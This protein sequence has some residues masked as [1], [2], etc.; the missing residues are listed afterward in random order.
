MRIILRFYTLILIIVIGWL[1]LMVLNKLWHQ[2]DERYCRIILS[3]SNFSALIYSWVSFFQGCDDYQSS[4]T[5]TPSPKIHKSHKII[6]SNDS[7]STLSVSFHF[8]FFL[9]HWIDF[10]PNL[11]REHHNHRCFDYLDQELVFWN[12]FDRDYQVLTHEQLIFFMYLFLCSIFS[13]MLSVFLLFTV[14]IGRSCSCLYKTYHEKNFFE[15][16]MFLWLTTHGTTQL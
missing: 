12:I 16:L 11:N 10:L 4:S 9:S 5:T 3:F 7:E 15:D 14:D 8:S 2:S 6:T 13:H 1:H